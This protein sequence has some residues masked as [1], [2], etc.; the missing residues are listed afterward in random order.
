MGRTFFFLE[1]E[2]ES[3]FSPAASVLAGV[4]DEI[5][6]KKLRISFPAFLGGYITN[7]NKRSELRHD[8]F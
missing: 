3:F 7:R 5:E 8:T 6:V 2:F 4:F 1:P